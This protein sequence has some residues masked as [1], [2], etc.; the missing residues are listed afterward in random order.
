[1]QVGLYQARYYIARY[2]TPC[3]HSNMEHILA[4]MAMLDTLP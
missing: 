2:I 3:S 4:T 1:M